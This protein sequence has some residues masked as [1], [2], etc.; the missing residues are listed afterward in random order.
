MMKVAILFIVIIQV[1][2][3]VVQG[4]QN[5]RKWNFHEEQL[6]TQLDTS[7]WKQFYSDDSW[8]IRSIFVD[9]NGDREDE[10]IALSPSGEDRMGN[11]W[12]IYRQDDNGK[13]KRVH[14]GGDIYFLCKNDSFY[15]LSFN[16]GNYIVVGLDMDTSYKDENRQR[17][18]KPMPDCI[19]ILTKDGKYMLHEIKPDLDSCFSR[20]HVASIE[21]LYPEW[22]FGYDFRPP[23]D[24]PHSVYTQRMPYKKPMGD[25]RSGGGIE[26]PNDFA[27]FVAEYR[28]GVKMR[29]GKNDKTTVYAIFLDADNDGDGDCYVSSDME[30]TAGG[31]YIWSLYLSHGGQFRKAKDAVFPVETRKGLCKLPNTVNAGKTSFCRVIRYDVPPIFV[32]VNK[33]NQSK[34][35]VRSAITDYYAHR[36][37]KLSCKTF[38]E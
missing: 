9:L 27:A 14:H 2:P 26:C 11:L 29:M 32:I 16:N 18:T 1:L 4:G 3:T 24:T 17:A 25:L 15:K 28:H 21:R 23:K 35:P 30:T 37:E 5:S 38:P 20:E 6:K 22:Y 33:G 8:R 7:W 34:S 19:F 10:L 31:E 36:I 13:F 12:A